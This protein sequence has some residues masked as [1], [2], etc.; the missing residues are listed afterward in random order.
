MGRTDYERKLEDALSAIA[1][2]MDKSGSDGFCVTICLAGKDLDAVQKHAIPMPYGWRAEIMSIA[3][4]YAT[5]ASDAIE[6]LDIGV[7]DGDEDAYIAATSIPIFAIG[8]TVARLTKVA[9]VS[10]YTAIPGTGAA[11]VV[12]TTTNGSVGIADFFITIRF[13]K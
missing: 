11:L 6:T 5:E 9:G 3:R 4:G 12:V 10:G 7:L 1:T 13:Y 2:G 8:N